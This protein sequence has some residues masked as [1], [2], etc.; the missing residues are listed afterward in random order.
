MREIAEELP[1]VYIRY[2]G[3]IGALKAALEDNV[4]PEEGFEPRP[5]QQQLLESLTQPAD[6]RTVIWVTD[7][8]GGAGKSR[9]TRHLI[10]NHGA[11]SLSGKVADM[12][13]AYSM[14]RAPIVCFDITRAAAE[15][16]TCLYSM[17]EKLKDGVLFI[18]KYQSRQI[19]F[20][21]PHVVYFSN[22]TWDRTKFSLDRVK[23]IVIA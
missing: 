5:W 6:D 1:A 20:Q 12:S 7:T 16:A 23:E 22:Q 21:P 8:Q 17:G 10:R 2:H 13:Y 4:V 14:Q 9:L 3:G 15:Y 19:V 18:T 11:L